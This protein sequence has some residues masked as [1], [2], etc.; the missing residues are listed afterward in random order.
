MP[1]DRARQNE[2]WREWYA[3]NAQRKYEWEA[4]RRLEIRQWWRE[5][6]ATKSCETCGEG[7]PE[8]LHF[9]HRDPAQKAFEISDAVSRGWS[10]ERILCE[11]A[12]CRVL[13]ANCHLKLHWDERWSG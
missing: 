5:L 1:T 11:L 7:S 6:K 12:K 4:R 10:R 3:R 2:L 8:C 9:H 13:C